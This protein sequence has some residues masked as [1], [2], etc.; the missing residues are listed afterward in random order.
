MLTTT[1]LPASRTS[2][3]SR[4]IIS[5]ATALPP[6]LFTRSTSATASGSVRTERMSEAIVRSPTPETPDSP[7]RI[8][9]SNVTTATYFPFV[10]GAGSVAR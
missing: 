3:S 4:R 8:S 9:P 6:G 1:G 5:L 2:S 7:S 10:A